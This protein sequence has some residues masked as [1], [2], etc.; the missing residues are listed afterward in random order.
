MPYNRLLLWAMTRALA[1]SQARAVRSELAAGG[2]PM[3]ERFDRAYTAA[4]F[5]EPL[6]ATAERLSS[7]G[8]VFH[9]YR[10]DRVSPGAGRSADLRNTPPSCATCSEP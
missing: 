4:V 10:F 5:A 3:Y 1:G 8:P 7:L 6:L 2:P 9:C